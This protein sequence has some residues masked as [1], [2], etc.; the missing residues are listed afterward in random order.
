MDFDFPWYDLEHSDKSV[1]TF[2]SLT[3]ATPSGDVDV[4]SPGPMGIYAD[5]ATA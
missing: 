1:E 3:R 4:L 5:G 2:S